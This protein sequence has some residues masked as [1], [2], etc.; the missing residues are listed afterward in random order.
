MID[1]Q[2]NISNTHSV[3]SYQHE[4]ELTQYEQLR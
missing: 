1:N 4:P 3:G 2:A